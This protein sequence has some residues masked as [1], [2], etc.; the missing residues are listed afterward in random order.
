[1]MLKINNQFYHFINLELSQEKDR[2]YFELQ[3]PKL[4]LQHT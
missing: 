3:A 4:T 2:I 1:M